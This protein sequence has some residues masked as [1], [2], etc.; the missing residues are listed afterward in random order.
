MRAPVDILAQVLAEQAARAFTF[1]D[2]GVKWRNTL[3]RTETLVETRESF[4]TSFGSCSFDEPVD[5][6]IALKLLAPAES[7]G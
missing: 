4:A 7:A 1:T 3:V 6:L 5:D 2:E